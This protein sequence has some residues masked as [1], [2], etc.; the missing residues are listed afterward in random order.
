[1]VLLVTAV[2]AVV[3]LANTLIAGAQS[4]TTADPARAS[5]AE[6]MVRD[7]ETAAGILA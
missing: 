5:R 7:A 2:G 4:L 1:M 3:L 6:A